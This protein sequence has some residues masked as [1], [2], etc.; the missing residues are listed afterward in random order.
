MGG[1]M[2]YAQIRNNTVINTLELEDSSLIYLF[3]ND[4]NGVPYDSLQLLDNMYPQPGIGWTFDNIVWNAPDAVVTNQSAIQIYTTLV[5]N[6]VA[7]GQS[8]TIQ[9]ATQNVMAGITQAGQT[10]AVLTYAANLYTYLST[11]SLYVAISEIETMIADT[12]STKTALSPFITNDILY[13]YLNQ[14]E[15]YLGIP[16]T[17]NP[18]P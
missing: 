2:I 16:L 9:F 1:V 15:G 10:Q 17:A 8:L 3:Q 12:S 4:H 14:I 5:T 11:G 7:F 6:A 13:V 18:G